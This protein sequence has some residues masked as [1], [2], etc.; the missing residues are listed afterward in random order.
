LG[1]GRSLFP[2]KYRGVRAATTLKELIE[3]KVIRNRCSEL[4]A[5][6]DGTR[7]LAKACSLLESLGEAAV[8]VDTPQRVSERFG[9]DAF[10]HRQEG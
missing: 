8:S 1:L 5:K 3:S 7:A 6:M 4:G 2:E 9:D 10:G